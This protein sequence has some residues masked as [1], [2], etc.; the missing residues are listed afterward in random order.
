M[1][2]DTPDSYQTAEGEVWYALESEKIKEE[3]LEY[4]T[5]MEF[6]LYSSE[7]TLYKDGEEFFGDESELRGGIK[8]RLYGGYRY[9]GTFKK[10]VGENMI[11]VF[12]VQTRNGS[13]HYYD[14][15]IDR[16]NLDAIWLKAKTIAR[17]PGI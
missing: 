4:G 7:L 15:I 8:V 1:N 13:T 6:R 9:Q 16:D 5:P 14:F 10:W 17:G 12:P 3:H 11:I 2:E